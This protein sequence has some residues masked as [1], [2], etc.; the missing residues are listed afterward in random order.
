MEVVSAGKEQCV[1]IAQG[2]EQGR[3]QVTTFP[4]LQIR[5]FIIPDQPTAFEA[6]QT[7]STRRIGLVVAAG[8]DAVVLQRDLGAEHGLWVAK[9]VNE[10]LVHGTPPIGR[11]FSLLGYRRRVVDL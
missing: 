5:T 9:G 11:I 1:D 6:A 4:A 3:F 2:K 7:I 10:L 8:V